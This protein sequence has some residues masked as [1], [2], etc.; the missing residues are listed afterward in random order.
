LKAS[1][2]R[3]RLGR[4]LQQAEPRYLFVGDG[5]DVLPVLVA[6]AKALSAIAEA[7]KHHRF[8]AAHAVLTAVHGG[9]VARTQLLARVADD[10]RV[11]LY[12]VR[13][14]DGH[15]HTLGYVYATNGAA[16][17]D[18]WKWRGLP[19]GAWLEAEA[20]ASQSFAEEEVTQTA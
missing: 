12:R 19:R 18:A 14:L 15:G 13:L 4:S 1:V 6:D 11:R 2:R 17:L 7:D 5:R 9:L 3:R 10:R 16:A 8:D 20:V